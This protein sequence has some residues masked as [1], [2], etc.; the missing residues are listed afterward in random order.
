ME[1]GPGPTRPSQSLFRREARSSDPPVRTYLEMARRHVLYG[2]KPPPSSENGRRFALVL[3]DEVMD[4]EKWE[5]DWDGRTFADVLARCWLD[6]RDPEGYQVLIR[7]SEESPVIWDALELICQEVADRGEA[8]PN[9]LLKWSFD[10]SHGRLARP[11]EGPAPRH[12]PAKLG[13]KFRNNEIRHTVNLLVLVGLP[14]IAGRSAV[15]KAFDFALSRIGQICREPYFTYSDLWEDVVK[16]IFPSY[17]E[18]LL[19]SLVKTRFEE[20]PAV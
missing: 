16:R 12:R 19:D 11:D 5:T 1:K 10:A 4:D 14:K 15:A 13:Y 20:V 6:S 7:L 18:F 9:E 17:Y 8:R 3:L 2:E